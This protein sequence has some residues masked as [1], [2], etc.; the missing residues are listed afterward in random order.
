METES[1]AGQ[2]PSYADAKKYEVGL[3]QWLPVCLIVLL[4]Y[5]PPSPLANLVMSNT[6]SGSVRIRRGG[7]VQAALPLVGREE[8][9]EGAGPSHHNRLFRVKGYLTSPGPAP[10]N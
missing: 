7:K 4:F 9:N 5:P 8:K 1:N 6:C 2:P 3:L 10:E